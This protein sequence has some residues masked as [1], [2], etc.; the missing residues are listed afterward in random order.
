V[1]KFPEKLILETLF[2]QKILSVKNP[3]TGIPF[4]KIHIFP[5]TNT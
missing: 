1:K 2:P 3:P 4:K 5:I